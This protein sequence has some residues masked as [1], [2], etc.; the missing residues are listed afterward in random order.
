MNYILPL[1]YL[2]NILYYAHLTSGRCT[3]DIHSNYIKQTYTNRCSIISANG[4]Q[5]LTI[6]IIKP[7]EKTPIKDIRISSHDNWQQLH[8]R[9]IQSAYNSTP[10]Y[11]YFCDDY[12]PFYQKKWDFL[13]DFNLKIQEKT[14]ELLNFQKIESY[15][16]DTYIEKSIFNTKDLREVINPKKFDVSLYNNLNTPYYQIFNQKFGF[17]PNLS[18]IDLLFN[19]GNEARIYLKKINQQS[20]L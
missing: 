11:E 13:L 16:S 17:M 7:K 1:T 19:M 2:G 3:I 12:L 4:I 6:P 20:T 10:F 15:L 14:L 9:A 5:D 18:I 8:W